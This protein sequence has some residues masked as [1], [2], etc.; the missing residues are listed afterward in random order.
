MK[1][2]SYKI[3]SI[4]DNLMLKK[5][6][7]DNFLNKYP[8]IVYHFCQQCFCFIKTDIYFEKILNCF[9]FF[10]KKKIK[11]EK[12]VNL[13]DFYNALVI[14]MIKYYKT[15][16]K[17]DVEKIKKVYNNFIIY[18]IKNNDNN[19]NFFDNKITL[20]KKE[21]LNKDLRCKR[22]RIG[23]DFN[24]NI[25]KKDKDFVVMEIKGNY[26][27]DDIYDE[28]SEFND[29]IYKTFLKYKF[30]SSPSYENIYLINPIE[31]VLI[32]I[33]D[34]L[35]LV[36]IEQPTNEQLWKARNSI[37]F[38]KNLKIEKR[39]N[40]YKSDIIFYKEIGKRNNLKKGIFCVLD[41]SSE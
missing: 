34:F 9:K 25:N 21:I 18:L 12:I 40:D 1:D 29:F 3:K 27:I 41:L 13:I 16:E 7:L 39:N 33:K 37:N 15:L 8:E 19:K 24:N 36:N 35:Y 10:A 30:S 6:V 5:I 22:K 32:T 38:Y 28:D 20:D 11:F 23:N 31:K 14:E 26:L 4:S 17:K 2:G